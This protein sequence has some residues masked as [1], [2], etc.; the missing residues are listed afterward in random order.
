MCKECE[1]YWESNGRGV[2][3]IPPEVETFP[4]H[5]AFTAGAKEGSANTAG[6]NER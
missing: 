3:A 5:P 1:H 2:C 4:W 6:G